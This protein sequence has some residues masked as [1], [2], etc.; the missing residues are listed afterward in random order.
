[1]WAGVLDEMGL[2]FGMESL[3]PNK[4][5]SVGQMMAGERDI[6]TFW[7]ARKDRSRVFLEMYVCIYI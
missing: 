7:N 5:R 4:Q 6:L 1:M 3:W 2:Q